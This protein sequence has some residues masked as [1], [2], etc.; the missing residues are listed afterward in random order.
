[1]KKIACL[2]LVLL[3]LFTAFAC[4]PASSADEATPK[5]T[6]SASPASPSSAAV[7]AP[8][9]TPVPASTPVTF[10][11]K[12]YCNGEGVNLR[13]EPAT[14]ADVLDILG[15]NVEF[16][17]MSLKDG[18]YMVHY[19]G[20]TAY[21]KEDLVTLGEPPRPHNM[22]WAKVSVP[23]AQLYKSLSETDLSEVKLK[24]G[25]LV[26]V[27]RAL[28]GYLHVVYNGTL[29]RYMKETDITF[30]TAEEAAAL[31]TP[32]PGG[33]GTFPTPEDTPKPTATP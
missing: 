10:P 19:E 23:E 30:I 22:R 6:P 5:P 13:A 8:A 15:E 18:W 27:L 2:I 33:E 31:M 25:D 24:E 32:A 26:K 7:A 21:I 1:M 12:G 4:K 9:Y 28:N 16:D 14:S 29:Q 11:A 20:V 3:L 17:V